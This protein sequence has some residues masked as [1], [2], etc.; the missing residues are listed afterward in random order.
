MKTYIAGLVTT[1]IV[2]IGIVSFVIAGD[3]RGEHRD[4]RQDAR[5]QKFENKQ[6]IIYDMVRTQH[7]ADSLK[8]DPYFK[9]ALA[10]VNHSNHKPKVDTIP[11]NDT[12][13]MIIDHT[14]EPSETLL[15]RIKFR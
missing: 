5:L 10:I 14:K 12:L 6:N 4:D 9:K 1:A 7:I 15:M 2:T 3:T 13:F 11:L 8:N